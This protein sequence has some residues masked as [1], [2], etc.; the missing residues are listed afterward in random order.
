MPNPKGSPGDLYAEVKIML[1]KRL[2]ERERELF[3]ELARV[4]D[5]DPRR[6]R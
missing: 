2:N 5:F 1:P 6:A 3:E 4:S